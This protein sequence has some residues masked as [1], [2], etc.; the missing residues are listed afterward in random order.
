MEGGTR[1]AE[2]LNA[3]HK[4]PLLLSFPFC[5]PP[6][7][8]PLFSFSICLPLCLPLCVHMRVYTCLQGPSHSPSVDF[9]FGWALPT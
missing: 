2:E 8:S 5:L 3:A 7:L 9:L 1:K 4:N 6:F